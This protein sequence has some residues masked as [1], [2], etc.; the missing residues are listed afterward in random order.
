MHLIS[1]TDLKKKTIKDCGDSNA[2]VSIRK[3]NKSAGEKPH[4]W[5]VTSVFPVF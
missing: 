3:I 2:S 4:E 5:E 1:R